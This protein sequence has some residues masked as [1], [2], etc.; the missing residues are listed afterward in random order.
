MHTLNKYMTYYR[1][2]IANWWNHITF[3]EYMTLMIV[4]LV[5]GYLMLKCCG[6][7]TA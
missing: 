7:R 2:G 5:A 6:G 1:D 3:W 4:A